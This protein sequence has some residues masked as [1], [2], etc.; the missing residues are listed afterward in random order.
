MK[1]GID[2][3]NGVVACLCK[4]SGFFLYDVLPKGRTIFGCI[5]ASKIAQVGTE[6]TFQHLGNL[7]TQIKIGIDVEVGHGENL[8]GR[9]FLIGDAVFPIH[10][11]KCKILTEH[12]GKHIDIAA[13]LAYG[14]GVVR[15]RIGGRYIVVLCHI[16]VVA[17]VVYGNPKSCACALKA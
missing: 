1:I 4:R 12:G 7:K 16:R 3:H 8:L 10:K 17:N 6:V 15:S 14:N 9:G 5:V 2:I 11:T 13:V